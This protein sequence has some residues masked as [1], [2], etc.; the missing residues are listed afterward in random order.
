MKD[1]LH[2]SSSRCFYMFYGPQT[3]CQWC[4]GQQEDHSI[5]NMVQSQRRDVQMYVVLW[6]STDQ[7][8]VWSHGHI[9]RLSF[10]DLPRTSCSPQ[11]HIFSNSQG[12][13]I[14]LFVNKTW[15]QHVCLLF[16]ARNYNQKLTHTHPT[17]TTPS[18]TPLFDRCLAR[19]LRRA[20]EQRLLTRVPAGTHLVR[21]FRGHFIL[22]VRA[23]SCGLNVVVFDNH[24]RRFRP[25][26]F[27]P[28]CRHA[29]LGS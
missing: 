1:S 25:V 9:N 19:C 20:S 7:C 28:S 24:W 18:S 10:P 14:P 29:G 8:C 17:E 12:G 16:S 22:R 6:K 13:K 21:S 26:G 15:K 27:S 4:N 2:S 23:Q 5:P 11:H 3:H